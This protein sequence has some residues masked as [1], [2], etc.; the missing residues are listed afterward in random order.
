MES[1]GGNH[2]LKWR[3]YNINYVRL[4]GWINELE[5]NMSPTVAQHFF[6]ELTIS[7]DRVDDFYNA[8]EDDLLAQIGQFVE[9]QEDMDV[10]SRVRT[11]KAMEEELNKLQKYADHNLETLRKVATKFDGGS[12]TVQF[13]RSASNDHGSGATGRTSDWGSATESL[14]R[15]LEVRVRRHRFGL[16]GENLGNIRNRL[17]ALK[18]GTAVSFTTDGLTKP[19]LMKRQSGL[20]D[21]LLPKIQHEKS[22]ERVASIWSWLRA[23]WRSILYWLIVTGAIVVMWSIRNPESKLNS[24]SYVVIWV[25]VVALTLLAREW[26]SD[27]VM[28]GATLFLCIFGLISGTEAWGGF[29]N[30]VVLSVAA[31]SVVGD[32]VSHTGFVDIL[33]A[34]LIGNPSSLPM[35]MLRI[36]IPT[37]LGAATISNTAVMACCMPAIEEWCSKSGYHQALFFMPISYI[38]LI[39]GTFAIFS[40]STN[41]VAQAQLH[42]NHLPEFGQ[43]D[44]G[45]PSL[46]CSAVALIYLIVATPRLLQRFTTN[47][48]LAKSGSK[49]SVN[50]GR[51]TFFARLRFDRKKQETT[52]ESSGLL[53]SGDVRFVDALERRGFSEEMPP[54]NTPLRFDD[55]LTVR[56][57]A[58]GMDTLRNLPGFSVLSLDGSEIHAAHADHET[59]EL[60]E[61]VL[62][63]A[64]PLTGK[65]LVNAGAFDAYNGA[66]L[67]Y[68]LRVESGKPEDASAIMRRI[69]F[70]EVPEAVEIQNGMKAAMHISPASAHRLVHGDQLVLDVPRDFHKRWRDS[71]DFLM[72]RKIGKGKTEIDTYKAY[73]SGVILFFMI[74]FVALSILPLFVCALSAIFLL[75]ASGCSTIEQMKKGVQLKVVLTIV[76]AFGV[77]NAIGKH[78]IAEVFAAALVSIFRPL[79]N[80]GLLSGISVAVVALGVIFHGTAVVSLMFPLCYHVHLASGIPLHQI[81]AVLCISVA[82]QMLSPVSYNTN[83]MA[84]AACPEYSFNDFP[85]LGAPLVVLILLFGIPLCTWWF[86]E[87]PL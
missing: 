27:G 51:R 19:E 67:A 60:V 64:S 33:F 55:I 54:E 49:P 36:L 56:I 35:A 50:T 37:A 34:K 43:F 84:Y 10:A 8:K 82:C 15:R 87:D 68:R 45:V 3:D 32:A 71:P 42:N 70:Q 48:D 79:G 40:T 73:V 16:A 86:P 26:P 77:G 44:M 31:L 39:A 57:S 72:L 28:L 7:L 17:E 24:E 74:F 46:I 41:L 80:L 53:S 1:S 13:R 61:L 78:G 11:V 85:K 14:T 63:Q 52:I 6:D 30:E 59:R 65:E 20:A 69:S 76:G 25:T 2:H 83:L 58:A 38:M 62:D 23:N 81:T 18:S 29:S 4:N 47:P 22:H 5:K 21:H 12:N 75:V 66:V 9:D